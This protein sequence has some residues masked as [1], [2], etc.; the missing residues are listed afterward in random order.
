MI[1]FLYNN[2]TLIE[3]AR[4]PPHGM[5]IANA[6]ESADGARLIA[7]KKSSVAGR[8]RKPKKA[9]TL[10]EKA[11]QQ[12]L[13]SGNIKKQLITLAIPLLFG[14]ILQ[15][16]YNTADSLIVGHFLG[17]DAFASVGVSGS[18]MNLFIFVLNGFCVGLSVILGQLYGNGDRKQ[19]REEFFVAVGYGTILTLIIS[20][21]SMVLLQTILKLIQTPD[22]LIPYSTAYLMMILAGLPF[23]Y[24]Y[25][26]FSNVLRSVGNTKAGLYFLAIAIVA[27]V[28]LDFAFIAGLGTGT[29]GAAAATVV[30]QFF[31]AACCFF[32]LKKLYPELICRKED[33]GF[34]PELL[35]RT[36]KYGVTSAMQASSLY[37]GKV[38]VQG[39][40]NTLGT[41]GIAAYTATMRIEGFANSFG[42]SGGSAISVLVSQNKGAGNTDRVKKGMK[43]GVT[44]N[45]VLGLTMAALMIVFAEP[46]IRLFISDGDA[47]S[48]QYGVD[49]LRIVSIFY[50]FCFVGS[51]LVGYFRGIGKV[52]VPFWCSTSHITIRV[53]LSYLLV[54]K[55]G[56]PAIGL[57]TGIGWIWAVTYQMLMYF[58]YRKQGQP[59][60]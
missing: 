59:A 35:S 33:I 34:H 47:L 37:I 32:Y 44:L 21:V 51:A 41:P 43:D 45:L 2:G 27:N 1:F 10:M 25:N 38:L 23:T 5:P 26:L 60:L 55:L 19:F 42:D 46:G 29:A 40:V 15:Q 50:V 22:E 56:L 16:L 9:G 39:A 28:I 30:S 52:H 12:S 14:N 6:N 11:K 20:G 48:I 7:G 3:G 4:L 53:I 31:S 36:L 18:I 17:T 49:Y 54:E 24:F 58:H 57:A 13:L 8:T